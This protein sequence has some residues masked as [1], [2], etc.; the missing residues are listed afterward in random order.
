MNFERICAK[1]NLNAI[2]KNVESVRNVIP[3]DT[4][5]MAIVKA[6]AYGHGSVTLSQYLDDKVDWFGVSN[7]YEGIELRNNGTNKPILILGATMPAEIESI[8]EYALT[9]AIFDYE[10]AKLLSDVAIEKNTIVNVHIKVD[11]GMSRIGFQCTDSSI[12]E[13]CKISVLPGIHI[14]GIFSHFAKADEADKTSA[15]VQMEKFDLFVEKLVSRGIAPPIKHISNSA[16]IME[17]NARYNMV[18]MGIMLYGLYPSDE[19]NTDFK[20]YPAMELKSHVTHVK[21]TDA[22]TGVSY[23]HTYVTNKKTKIA[24]IPVGYAD[25]YP[26]CLSNKGFVLINSKKCPIIGR[27]C[28]D[29]MMIDVTDMDVSIGDD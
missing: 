15:L 25:G 26:R 19:V 7:A 23:G 9:P 12:D 16:G 6:D 10:R 17:L 22:G 11:T 18:R 21:E 2:A 14:E 13:I 3:A 8:V 28:M 4:M 27:I 1:V 29:Q 24:T 20:L 5:I